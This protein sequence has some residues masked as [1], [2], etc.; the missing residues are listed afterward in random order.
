MHGTTR[1]H[2]SPFAVI[3]FC[4]VF[5]LSSSA[6]PQTPGQSL[7]KE[8][9]SP[10]AKTSKL[11]QAV[12]CPKIVEYAPRNPAIVFPISIGKIYCFT[13]FDP[14][15]EKTLVYHSWF[16]RDSLITTKRMALKPPKWSTFSTIQ[17]REA[18]IGPWRV[19]INDR[20]G[21]LLQVLRFSITD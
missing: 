9:S 16:R 17:L 1:N 14:V 13:S 2:F 19:E 15:T 10:E 21:N 6:W 20:D 12:M 5:F 8:A 7:S 4:L 18:D 3:L 11:V